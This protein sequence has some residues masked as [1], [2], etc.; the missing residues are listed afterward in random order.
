MYLIDMIF[1][2]AKSDPQRHALV[3]PDLITTYSGLADAIESIAAR[4]EQLGLNR[5]EPIAVSISSPSFFAA[6]VFALLRNGYSAAL[7]RPGLL[8]L[9]Q[10][11]GIRNLIYDSQG[12]M[13]SGGRNVRFDPSWLSNAAKN[14]TRLASKRGIEELDIIFFTSGTTGLPKKVAQPLNAL[15]QL[16]KYPQ[17]CASGTGQK[18]LV[19]PGLST[20]FGFNRLCEVL[21]AGKSAFF[22]SDSSSALSLIGLHGVEVVVASASQAAELV[23][24]RNANPGYQVGSLQAI[25]VGGGKIEPQ[26]IAEIRATLCRN[27]INQYGSTEAGVAALTPFDVLADKPG[28]IALP[29]TELQIVDETG[30]QLPAGAEGLIRYRTPQLAENLKRA[31]SDSIPGVRDGWFYP[32]DIGSLTAAGI[33]SFAGRS[34]DVINRGGVKVSGNRIEEILRALP[35]IKEA[36]ACGIAGPSGLEEIWI[37][38]EANGPVDIGEIEKLLCAHVDIGIAPDEVFVLDELPRG[39]LGKVQKLRLKELLRSRKRAA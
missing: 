39:E 28:A 3:Q 19:M 9:L 20:T 17:T 16:L 25:F 29:W 30:Q 4:I 14:E 12:L 27:V 1:Y 11:A 24:A 36:A 35:Q 5:R 33:L 21:N 13:L 15:D 10:S 37:A 26:G 18:I 22:A 2:W 38:I 32:G 31:G 7:V 34:S 23:K 6:I 8:P